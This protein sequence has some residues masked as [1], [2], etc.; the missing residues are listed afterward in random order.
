MDALDMLKN[1][2]ADNAGEAEPV[3]TPLIGPLPAPAGNA[4]NTA[5]RRYKITDK[6]VFLVTP[7]DGDDKPDKFDFVCSKLD[8]VAMIRDQ[9][10]GQWGKLLQWQDPDGHFHEWAMPMAALQSDGAEVRREFAAGGL[11]MSNVPRLRDALIGYLNETKTDVRAR[12]VSRTGWYRAID[13]HVFVLPDQAIGASIEVLRYQSANTS[14]AYSVMGTFDGWRTEVAALCAG[15]SRCVLAM[16]VGFASLLLEFSG[17]ESGGF[18]FKGSSSTGKT[19]ALAAA[20]SVFGG[21][22]YINRWRA[23]SN[24]VES[25]AALHNDTLLILD[26]LAQ[27]DPK[28]AGEIAYML[29]N[30]QGKQR[31]AKTGD[32]KHRQSWRLLFLSA[33]EIGLAQHMAD[34]G[35]KAKAGQ[36]VRLVDLEAD[37]GH[38]LG[39]FDALHD[40]VDGASLSTA[41]KAGATRHYGHAVLAF[42]KLLAD[43]APELPAVVRREMAL[44]TNDCL[45]A[46]QSGGQAQRVCERF[47]LA[48]I[49]GELATTNDITGWQS[50]EAVRA[51][52]RCFAEWLATRGGSKNIEPAAMVEA[53]R[54]FISKNEEARFTDLDVVAGSI[55]RPT[56]NRAGWR[57]NSVDGREYLI[58]PAVFKTEVSA[59]FDVTAV[60]RA[61]EQSGC[62][63]STVEGGQTRYSGKRRI[64]GESRRVYAISNR[65]WEA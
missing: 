64:E 22:D 3:I 37:A 8:V 11:E 1:P 19:T 36:E 5:N 33:G 44:F 2:M 54:S 15:N 48:A 65:I 26:E 17:L 28:E 49:A 6:G 29:A 40:H 63:V 24:G 9:H 50:G 58:D 31:S 51:A 23:T 7:G 60:C 21:P 16:S 12:G 25:L 47:A 39:L 52:K 59:G 57:R 53:V 43:S 61:L 30:G 20:A 42:A 41:I 38:G 62:L 35:K 34:G 55:Y 46:S 32:A 4:P 10:S 45:P 14:R 56:I 18:N 27:V 13:G